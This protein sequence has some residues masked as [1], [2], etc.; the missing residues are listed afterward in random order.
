MSKAHV[1]R[2]GSIPCK[3]RSSDVDSATVKQKSAR[4]GCLRVHASFAAHNTSARIRTATMKSA[5]QACC[6]GF[7]LARVATHAM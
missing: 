4:G 7:L 5:K 2:R 1:K 3:S 6:G